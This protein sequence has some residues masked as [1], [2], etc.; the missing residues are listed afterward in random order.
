MICESFC[1]FSYDT[2]WVSENLWTITIKYV[3]CFIFNVRLNSCPYKIE[4][5]IFKF[6]SKFLDLL[7]CELVFKSWCI[8]TKDIVEYCVDIFSLCD[9]WSWFI[10]ENVWCRLT[11]HWF[12][13]FHPFSDSLD[14]FWWIRWTNLMFPHVIIITIKR[15]Y[16]RF[17]IP[18]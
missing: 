3:F 7:R 9:F 4:N 17:C 12:V 11:V 16:I 10:V 5:W 13:A 15:G 2:E 6:S 8:Q 18:F 1:V 14:V